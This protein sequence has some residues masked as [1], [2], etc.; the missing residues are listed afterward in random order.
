M[1]LLNATEHDRQRQQTKADLVTALQA[2]CGNATTRSQLVA[3]KIPHVAEERLLK[4][5]GVKVSRAMDL[6]SS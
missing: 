2:A 5:Y 1:A 3:K 6:R 4:T